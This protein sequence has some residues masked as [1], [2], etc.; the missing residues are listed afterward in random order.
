MMMVV[1]MAVVK[2]SWCFNWRAVFK[3]TCGCRGGS[4]GENNCGG[5]GDVCVVV[6]EV[7]VVLVMVVLIAVVC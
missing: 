6:K 3:I 1:G 4:S 5:C 7:V 2:S